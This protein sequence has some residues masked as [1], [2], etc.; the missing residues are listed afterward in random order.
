MNT[1]IN[2]AI[3]I[4]GRG[5]NAKNI[6]N[7]FSGNKSVKVVFVLSTKENQIISTL[8]QD[9]NIVFLVP[10]TAQLSPTFYIQQLQVL[11][12]DWIIL[13]GF[14]RKIPQE[15]IL[16]YPNKIINLH[17]SLLPSFGGK[18]MYGDFVHQAVLAS[19]IDKSGISIH[20]V[21][22]QFDKGEIIAQFSC[23]VDPSDTVSILSAKIHLLEQQHFPQIIEK[24][25]FE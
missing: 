24:T 7:Y 4:S 11:H 21:N 9:K 16:H 20:Y 6:I 19:G 8:C 12:I 23:D 22:E 25:I 2:I 18:G 5:T 14:L 1:T 3:F 17:P 10:N 15:L 13:A